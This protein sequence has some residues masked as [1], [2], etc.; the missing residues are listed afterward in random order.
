MLYTYTT[1]VYSTNNRVL[2]IGWA[3]GMGRLGTCLMSFYLIPLIGKIKI[4]FFF[5]KFKNIKL[6]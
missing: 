4:K 3:T 5:Y 1:E 2:G 6:K